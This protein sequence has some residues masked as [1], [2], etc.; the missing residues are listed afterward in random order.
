MVQILEKY[1]G[2]PVVKGD[3]WNEANW[4]WMHAN[5]NISNDGL[6]DTLLLSLAVLTDQKNSST[7]VL[8]LDQ[9]EFGLRME[10]LVRG[11]EDTNVK[12][13]YD[14]MVDA[15]VIFG[16]NKSDAERE[17]LDSLKFEIELAKVGILSIYV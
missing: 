12:A 2:W 15:A 3:L 10:F 7:R 16:A 13:Y 4:E 1:G 11:I 8:D 9:P 5:R 6:D 14:F 17:L